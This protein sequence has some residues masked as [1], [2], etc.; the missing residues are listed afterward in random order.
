VILQVAPTFPFVPG[1]E[2]IQIVY[3]LPTCVKVCRPALTPKLRRPMPVAM[4]RVLGR[5]DRLVRH[6]P[7]MHSRGTLAE[8]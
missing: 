6:M 5:Q 1:E 3:T 2:H 8:Q 7:T 4:R